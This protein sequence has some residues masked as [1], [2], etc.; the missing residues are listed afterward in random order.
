MHPSD[1]TIGDYDPIMR[2]IAMFCLA[3]V[4]G[5]G[6]LAGQGPAHSA[7]QRAYADEKRV[8]HI[9]TAEGRDLRISPEKGQGDVERIQVA[10]DGR[11]VGWLVDRLE[12]CQSYP[13]PTELIIW[14]SGRVLRRLFTGRPTWGWAFENG[15]KQLAYRTSF[16]HGGWSGELT[17]IDVASGKTMASWSHPVDGNG[18]DTEGEDPPDWAK[19]VQ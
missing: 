3:V 9:V 15:G 7:V 5:P 13:I 17:L 8:V 4:L 19:P 18:N 16:A 12:C 6:M 14:R 10:T 2:V 1:L 11:T